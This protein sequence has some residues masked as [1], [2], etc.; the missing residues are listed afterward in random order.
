[1][2]I[3]FSA[4]D[5]SGGLVA[6]KMIG[7]RAAIDATLHVDHAIEKPLALDEKRRMMLVREASIA[8]GLDHSNIV[9][10]FDYGQHEG[11][12][13]IVMEYLPGRSL[14]K[15]VP[16]H[17][18]VPLKTKISL[19]RQICEALDYAHKQGVLH[20]DV[21]PANA[22]VLQDAKLKMLDFGLAARL[23]EPL[24]GEIAFVGT[25]QYMAPELVAGSQGFDA[26][27]DIWATGVTLYQFLTGRLPFIATSIGE[28]L[29]NITREQFPRLDESFPHKRELER[30][31]DRAL[32]KNPRNR[33]ASA[34]DFALDLRQ[35]EER[36]SELQSLTPSCVTVMNDEPGSNSTSTR[37]AFDPGPL[38]SEAS[39]TVSMISGEIRA[40]RSGHTLRF[41][42]YQAKTLPVILAG[43]LIAGS[44]TFYAT[45]TGQGVASSSYDSGWFF[46]LVVC[47]FGILVPPMV[48]VTFFL[49]F[50]VFY[51][52]IAGIPNC[53][54]CK[55]WME[56]R[57]RVS[58]FA[59]SRRSWAHAS[60]DCLAALKEG[61]WEDA[62]KLLSMHGE[63]DAPV[64]EENTPHRLTSYPMIRYHL[65]FFTCAQCSDDCAILT[66]EDKL[67]RIWNPRPEF[68]GAYR[69]KKRVGTKP[70]LSKRLA[71]VVRGT[72]RAA[73]FAVARTTLIGAAVLL[74][75]TALLAFYYDEQVPLILGFPGYRA[76][77]TIQSDPAGQSVN[78]DGDQI[79]TPRTFSWTYN[80]LHKITG[81]ESRVSNGSLLR[82]Q[83]VIP[84]IKVSTVDR[85]S[86]RE[87]LN[88]E[89][90]VAPTIDRW[91][92]PTCKPLV[93]LY[94]VEFAKFALP[95][96]S[97]AGGTQNS[98]GNLARNSIRRAP[99][100]ISHGPGGLTRATFLVTSDPAGLSVTVDRNRITTPRSYEWS[101]GSTHT[102]NVPS[103]I[104][105]W[106][107]ATYR[108]ESSTET[109]YAN[110]SWINSPGEHIISVEVPP[111]RS[112]LVSLTYTAR[113]QRV[114]ANRAPLA[115][116]ADNTQ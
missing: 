103:G 88:G 17:A 51:E 95:G 114:A 86:G 113:F 66:T 42:E 111:V 34:G 3:V 110:G 93:P 55:G 56:N 62:A 91:G 98:F 23:R 24:P 109:F 85:Y 2:G 116:K 43:I 96:V 77:I 15:V 57:S 90:K 38:R 72:W 1:M 8:M 97:D 45:I 4:R 40:R 28:M 10:V 22:M 20:R 60:S 27:S 107:Q 41:A 71:N 112:N 64:T 33:Y 32:A 82:F 37:T 13:Y 53:Q 89:L 94:T 47:G 76:S 6:I 104:R 25:P 79:T 7:S 70:S 44:F 35:L 26:R 65:D 18:S 83:R 59:H 48:A 101:T 73:Q 36:A 16:I 69:R 9:R 81:L 67:G 39:E 46:V 87:V 63:V 99:S 14:D 21:K 58:S 49:R 75:P 52:A 105:V 30:I 54:E 92:R 11:L 19:I 68:D 31:L 78:V 100:G 84:E 61:L 50:L 115:E 80:S 5:S 102:L 12:L 108:I 106:V 74:I 29:D